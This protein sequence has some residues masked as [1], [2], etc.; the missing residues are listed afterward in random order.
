MESTVMLTR[1]ERA[2]IREALMSFVKKVC[3]KP[4]ELPPEAIE[5]LPAVA[6][7]LMDYY[8]RF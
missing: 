1:E 2:E 3:D 7:V 4:E 6:N 8:G 5:V